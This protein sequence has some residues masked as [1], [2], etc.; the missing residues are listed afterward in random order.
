MSTCQSSALS[1]NDIRSTAQAAI[2]ILAAAG[3]V[4][5][6]VGSAAGS[7]HGIS[8]TPNDVDI[9][10]LSET[11][12]QAELKSLL[13]SKCPRFSLSKPESNLHASYSILKYSIPAPQ[14]MF[15]HVDIFLPGMIHLPPIPHDRIVYSSQTSLPV[16]PFFP[17]LLH[18][19]QAWIAHR[20]SPKERA[21]IKQSNDVQDIRELLKIAVSA[22]NVKLGEQTWLPPWFLQEAAEGVSEYITSHPETAD[23]WTK[24]G[25][26]VD[27]S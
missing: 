21:R 10:A 23:S 8:R 4:S 15:C 2:S 17:I 5:C 16:M 11:M 13:V 12:T 24:V 1:I 27:N 14:L 9:L 6:L 7:E 18:K 3:I 25:F 26:F 22:H 19:V 20:D